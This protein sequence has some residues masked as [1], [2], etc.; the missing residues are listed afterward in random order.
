MNT[1]GIVTIVLLVFIC[2]CVAV[3]IINENNGGTVEEA[4]VAEVNSDEVQL[5]DAVSEGSLTVLYY[6][7][8]NMRCNTCLNIEAYTEKAVQTGFPEKMESGVIELRVVNLDQPDNEH[9]VEDYELSNRSVVISQ[10]EN[11]TEV[12]WKRLD[13]VWQLVS[14]EDAFITYIQ[15]E[16]NSL[17]EGSA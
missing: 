4:V 16:T 14:D 10:L 5:P 15:E 12:E 2:V 3:V 11:G 7:H 8:G 9:F 13:Q 17:M 1:K 6:F